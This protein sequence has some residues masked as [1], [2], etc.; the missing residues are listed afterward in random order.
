MRSRYSVAGAFYVA[1]YNFCRVHE[2]LQTTPAIATRHH[3]KRPRDPAQ[4]AKLMI[5]I[6]SG[7][8]AIPTR[9]TSARHIPNGK[10]SMFGCTLAALPG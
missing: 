6:A 9:R 8:G 1:H 2:R 7:E 10:I 4:L 3:R 5:D